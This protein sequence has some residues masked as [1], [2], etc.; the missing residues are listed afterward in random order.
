[1]S[2]LENCD[3]LTTRYMN[4]H[5]GSSYQRAAIFARLKETPACKGVPDAQVNMLLDQHLPATPNAHRYLEHQFRRDTP[6]VRA[7]KHE[8]FWRGALSFG[9][10]LI[11]LVFI[12]WKLVFKGNAIVLYVAIAVAVGYMCIAGVYAVMKYGVAGVGYRYSHILGAGL[13]VSNRFNWQ[14]PGQQ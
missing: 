5:G 11:I 7:F 1:M 14:P 12:L 3:A 6:E 8:A 13:P 10:L 4:D 2:S 9:P